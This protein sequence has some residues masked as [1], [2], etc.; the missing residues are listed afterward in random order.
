MK[1]DGK[2]DDIYHDKYHRYLW[3]KTANIIESDSKYGAAIGI[4]KKPHDGMISKERYDL[5][6]QRE[7]ASEIIQPRVDFAKE[8]LKLIEPEHFIRSQNKKIRKIQKEE[9]NKR[10]I[11]LT[12]F[13]NDM[14][15]TMKELNDP[16]FFHYKGSLFK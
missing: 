7:Y 1:N 6:K 4:A 15:D 3:S 2:N 12:N 9:T 10:F 16:I 14:D 13:V 11:R 5:N 8:P